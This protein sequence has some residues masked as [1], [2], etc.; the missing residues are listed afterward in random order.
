MWLIQEGGRGIYVASEFAHSGNTVASYNDDIMNRQIEHE[1]AE[2]L[3]A[4]L[5]NS[6][7]PQN[8]WEVG[9][10][11]SGGKKGEVW[12]PIFQTGDIP[13]QFF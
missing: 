4:E 10:A 6:K 7:S 1:N 13:L 5:Q 3:S 9:V 11:K 2:K 12:T 8:I